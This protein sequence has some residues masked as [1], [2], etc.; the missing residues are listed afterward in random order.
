MPGMPQTRAMNQRTTPTKATTVAVAVSA[1]TAFSHAVRGLAPWSRDATFPCLAPLGQGGC[2]TRTLYTFVSKSVASRI[3]DLVS[4]RCESQAFPN[5]RRSRP[6]LLGSGYAIWS[7]RF[8]RV[9]T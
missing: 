4:Q 2:Y 5:N 7:R 9:L 1:K 8:P 6:L 3:V